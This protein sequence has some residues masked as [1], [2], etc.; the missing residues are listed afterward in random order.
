MC[1]P[2]KLLIYP[3][4]SIKIDLMFPVHKSAHPSFPPITES[5]PLPRRRRHQKQS[6]RSIFV[7]VGF[8]S[9]ISKH[10]FHI[11]WGVRCQK[12]EGPRHSRNGPLPKRGKK[13]VAEGL[14]LK[15]V[16]LDPEFVPAISSL[17]SLYAGEEGRL[18]DAERLYVWATHLDPDDADV[19]NNYGFFLETHGRSSEAMTQYER[20]M[21]AKPNHTVAIVNAARSLRTPEHSRR[22][23]E[24]YKR[25]QF[26]TWRVARCK[27][28][29]F[30]AASH[31]AITPLQPRRPTSP[32][33]ETR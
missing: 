24:L 31:G 14:F 9:R 11:H 29:I 16:H 23:E 32:P 27:T 10:R 13:E 22:A 26:N 17:A 7:N 21:T 1:Q 20:A 15:A 4:V 28:N 6:I 30:L 5:L 18:A 33:Q 3:A 19:L 12:M 8:D 2:P 25:S